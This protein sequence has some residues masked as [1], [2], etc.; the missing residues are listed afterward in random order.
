MKTAK[1]LDKNTLGVIFY[2]IS[3]LD[4]ILGKTHLQKLLF[5]TDLLSMKKL[6]TKITSIEYKRYKHGPYSAELEKYTN[7]LINLDYIEAKEFP[8]L[9]NNTKKYTRY[10]LKK[11]ISIK[12]NLLKS[13][14]P[15]KLLVIDE[16]TDSFGNLSLQNLL[17]IIYNLPIVKNSKMDSLLDIAKG[18][19][20][21]S[22]EEKAM[23]SDL[24]F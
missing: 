22:E 17:D 10:H 19:D 3:R 12:E 8:L 5:L 9:S 4:G 24:P 6:K 7:H 18:T 16:V 2:F 1:T 20:S 21:S 23:L 13:L 15:E 11:H 14:G